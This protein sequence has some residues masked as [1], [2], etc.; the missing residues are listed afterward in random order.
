ME[1]FWDGYVGRGQTLDGM[2][3][4][5]LGIDFGT[6]NSCVA[7]WRADKNKVKIIRNSSTAGV[8]FQASLFSSIHMRYIF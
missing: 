6:S 2:E 1:T 4:V 5:V 3:N 8:W 7:V